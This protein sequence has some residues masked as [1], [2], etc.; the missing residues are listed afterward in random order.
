VACAIR[1]GEQVVFFLSLLFIDIICN[2]DGR[3]AFYVFGGRRA[4][5]Q[6]GSHFVYPLFNIE[7]IGTI[8]GPTSLETEGIEDVLQVCAHDHFV[9]F[10]V[11]LDHILITANWGV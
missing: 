7:V 11:L 9:L 3:Q 8:V 1:L 5:L 10:V 6:A 2:R 4:A